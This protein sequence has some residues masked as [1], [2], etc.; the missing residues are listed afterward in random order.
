MCT[1]RGACLDD[2]CRIQPAIFNR[3]HVSENENSWTEGVLDFLL[4]I[5]IL[6]RTSSFYI[7][8]YQLHLK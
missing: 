6:L 3:P 1:E 2:M 7:G 4:S 8:M 5:I